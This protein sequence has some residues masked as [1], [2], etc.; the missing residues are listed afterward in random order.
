MLSHCD[1]S[2]FGTMLAVEGGAE[3]EKLTRCHTVKLILTV[4]CWVEEAGLAV[5]EVV[6]YDSLKSA[7]RMNDCILS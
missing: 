3:F 7:S 5:G 6:G 1:P 2:Q 4:N